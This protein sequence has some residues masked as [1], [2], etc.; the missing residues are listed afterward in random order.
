[1]LKSTHDSLLFAYGHGLASEDSTGIKN[2][3]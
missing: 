2:G 1:M 3:E